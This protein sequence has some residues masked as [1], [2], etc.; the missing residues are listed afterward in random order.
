MAKLSLLSILYLPSISPFARL[1]AWFKALWLHYKKHLIAPQ[2]QPATDKLLPLSA[3]WLVSAHA[4][5]LLRDLSHP[6]GA[7]GGA[8]S[9]AEGRSHRLPHL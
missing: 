6:A 2:N 5:P 7:R 3:G 4:L 9:S 1:R 8:A